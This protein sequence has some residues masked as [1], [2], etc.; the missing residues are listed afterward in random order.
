MVRHSIDSVN[1]CARKGYNLRITCEA[2]EHVTEANAVLMQTELGSARAKWAL[3]RLEG[4][5]K[6][7]RCGAQRARVMPCEISF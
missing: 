5:L 7:S 1:D 2:C 6:C 3:D 4:K